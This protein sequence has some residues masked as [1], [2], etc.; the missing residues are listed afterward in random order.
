MNRKRHWRINIYA[1]ILC[2]DSFLSFGPVLSHHEP[3]LIT[4]KL[5]ERWKDEIIPLHARFAMIKYTLGIQRMDE[6]LSQ[7]LKV[8]PWV[9]P[10]VN[11]KLSLPLATRAVC[12]E[13]I[14]YGS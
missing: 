5:G 8:K 1:P 4:V 13:T 3:V 7:K 14:T 9:G 10:S 6:P 2:Q 12:R 11:N